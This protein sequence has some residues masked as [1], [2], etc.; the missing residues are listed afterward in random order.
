MNYFECSH[1]ISH[2]DILIESILEV[3]ESGNDKIYYSFKSIQSIF[4]INDPKFNRNL[5]DWLRSGVA[6]YLKK[7]RSNYYE[8]SSI[9]S[10]LDLKYKQIEKSESLIEGFKI[11]IN[12]LDE[13]NSYI[14]LRIDN[15]NVPVVVKL[16][17]NKEI[18]LPEPKIK[19]YEE[20]VTQV[21]FEPLPPADDTLKVSEP[22]SKFE[23]LIRRRL[24]SSNSY[25]IA[26]VVLIACLL[27]FSIAAFM[28]YASFVTELL[29]FSDYA[30]YIIS[31]LMAIG[32][33]AAW[34][35]SILIFALKNATVKVFGY[36]FQ[37]ADIGTFFQ[38]I[39][40]SSH[41]DFIADIASEEIQKLVVVGSIIIYTS[42]IIN[43][44]SKL[45]RN[46]QNI[47]KDASED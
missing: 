9:I 16:V 22:E 41:F 1:D 36:N 26:T 45:S 42:F 18:K 38:I 37:V 47:N 8:S 20:M 25:M 44:L 27:P 11:I 4:D 3:N 30:K 21:N 35:M 24:M 34:D 23:S 2:N 32:L 15:F 6:T 10:V 29:S 12:W 13:M 19:K 28:R 33:C 7:G 31:V 14:C 43:Q 46:V 5:R 39:F 17:D 40:I